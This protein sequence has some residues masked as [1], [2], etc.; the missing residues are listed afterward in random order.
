MKKLINCYAVAEDGKT[1]F[2]NE[3]GVAAFLSDNP[4]SQMFRVGQKLTINTQ[5]F[6]SS[7]RTATL[8]GFIRNP[9]GSILAKLKW[10]KDAPPIMV[11]VE[12]LIRYAPP[13]FWMVIPY[14]PQ[15]RNQSTSFTSSSRTGGTSPAVNRFPSRQAA[16]NWIREER[17]M[18]RW[19]DF[20]ILESMG[21]YTPESFL[22]HE[23]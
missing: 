7:G 13:K 22:R 21:L 23:A 6:M 8:T 3:G 1:W 2:T 18:A 4:N 11:R 10:H 17:R 15:F 16:E 20:M 9:K 14:N 5:R 19:P 12:S